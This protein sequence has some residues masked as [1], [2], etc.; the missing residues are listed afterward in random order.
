MAVAKEEAKILTKLFDINSAEITFSIL[1]NIFKT[2]FAFL[3]P[4]LNFNRIRGFDV[5]VKAVSDPEKNPDKR[6]NRK[7]KI[8]SKINEPDII[9]LVVYQFHLNLFFSLKKTHLY[10]LTKQN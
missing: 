6:I 9:I 4:F 1:S 3:L 7:S 10:Y 5:A 8:I 2:N